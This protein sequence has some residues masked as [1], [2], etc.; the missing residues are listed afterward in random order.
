M[1]AHVRQGK[2]LYV[3]TCT[4]RE[5]PLCMHMYVKGSPLYYTVYNVMYSIAILQYLVSRTDRDCISLDAVVFPQQ[6]GKVVTQQEIIAN[7]KK[8]GLAAIR[9]SFTFTSLDTRGRKW[10]LSIKPC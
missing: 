9:G 8:K 4:S 6:H 1:Y 5:V 7:N 2:S 3:C 10:L